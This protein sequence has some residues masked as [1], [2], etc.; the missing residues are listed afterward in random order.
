MSKRKAKRSSVWSRRASF[1]P[2]NDTEFF[3]QCDVFVKRRI[4]NIIKV[5]Q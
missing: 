1:G 5:Q 2:P 4:H 3:M